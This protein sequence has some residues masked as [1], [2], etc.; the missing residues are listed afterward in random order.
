MSR[1]TLG[2]SAESSPSGDGR[3]GGR[4]T[5]TKNAAILAFRPQSPAID[6]TNFAKV[7]NE[8]GHYERPPAHA[9]VGSRRCRSASRMPEALDDLEKLLLKPTKNQRGKGKR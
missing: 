4:A 1:K 6:C 2:F 8:F 7:S 9:Q 3:L 5:G